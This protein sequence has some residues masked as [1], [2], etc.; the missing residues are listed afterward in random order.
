MAVIPGTSLTVT[1]P[2]CGWG[3]FSP[4]IPVNPTDTIRRLVVLLDAALPLLD[5][6]AMKEARR[7]AGKNV[8][9]V[10]AQN[11]AKAAHQLV[12]D[13]AKEFGVQL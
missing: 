5:F 9:E 11:R 3:R 8:R 10:T 4:E 1:A 2:G 12:Q 7:D 6:E 13:A